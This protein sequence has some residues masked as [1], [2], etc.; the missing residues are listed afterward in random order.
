MSPVAIRRPPPPPLRSPKPVRI[1]TAR[2]PTFD[3]Q[4]N[5]AHASGRQAVTLQGKRASGRTGTI[6]S[7]S[8]D[9][10]T[11]SNGTPPGCTRRCACRRRPVAQTCKGAKVVARADCW[12]GQVGR[13]QI[14]DDPLKQLARRATRGRKDDDL[15]LGAA[16]VRN[17]DNTTLTRAVHLKP[18]GEREARAE[19]C[20]TARQH[21][22]SRN[23]S[24]CS[25]WANTIVRIPK[26]MCVPIRSCHGLRVCVQAVQNPPRWFRKG[27][28]WVERA[29]I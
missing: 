17:K 5:G 7:G 24:K 13:R 22:A 6:E 19:D 26:G 4:S 1:A 8:C 3:L 21:R 10:R 12:G 29:F 23:G 28:R 2:T 14:L 16:S 20:N 27:I 9:H 25:I 11:R 18:E 15:T